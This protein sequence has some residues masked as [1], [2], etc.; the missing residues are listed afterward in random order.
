[1][2]LLNRYFRFCEV[3]KHCCS[4]RHYRPLSLTF[5]SLLP[6]NFRFHCCT[7]YFQCLLGGLTRTLNQFYGQITFY[8]MNPRF[9][10]Q[11]L[12]IYSHLFYPLWQLSICNG[13]ASRQQVNNIW[14][15]KKACYHVPRL[16]KQVDVHVDTEIWVC[17]FPHVE[18][19]ILIKYYHQR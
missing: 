9:C 16:V 1:M 8:L 2:C 10:L 17:G 18:A 12:C 3:Q 7:A 13:K 4:V 5:S 6:K 19:P 11:I 15:K 14:R